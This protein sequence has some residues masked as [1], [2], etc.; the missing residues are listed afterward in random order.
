MALSLLHL[1]QGLRPSHLPFFR[2]H[3]SQALG[4]R[5]RQ[6]VGVEVWEH[7]LC[8]GHILASVLDVASVVARA[9]CQRMV[10]GQNKVWSSFAVEG[11]AM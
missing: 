5:K 6:L 8:G 2:R 4:V 9:W 11:D 10:L 7:S 3:L 1:E